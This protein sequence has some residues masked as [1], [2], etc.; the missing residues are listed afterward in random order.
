MSRIL[1]VDDEESLRTHPAR[2]GLIFDYADALMNAGR[3][4]DALALVTRAEQVLPPDYR[5]YQLEARAHLALGQRLEQHR[6]QAEAYL[7]RGSVPAAIEQLQLGLRSG[8][9]DYFQLSSAE[10]R[11]KELQALDTGSRRRR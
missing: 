9:G 5:L 1:V 4:A 6:A 10:A 8:D 3:A 7:L 2:R 11:L